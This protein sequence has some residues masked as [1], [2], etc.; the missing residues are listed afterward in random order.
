MGNKMLRCTQHDKRVY[1]KRMH[2]PKSNSPIPIKEFRLDLSELT[3]IG[4]DLVCPESVLAKPDGTLWVSDG[5]GGV[6]RIGPD[7][8][9]TFLGGL[10][11][12]PNVLT[13]SNFTFTHIKAEWLWYCHR[14]IYILEV[15]QDRYRRP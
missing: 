10:S 11:G 6:T 7:G 4:H 12:E 5:R 1:T 14:T 13:T 3:Y 8:Q 2:E 15:F 9:Q